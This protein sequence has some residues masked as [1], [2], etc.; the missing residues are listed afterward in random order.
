[1]KDIFTFVDAAYAVHSNMRI[2]TG[3]AMSMGTGI[4]H[5]K[6]SKQ[7]INV[8]SSTEAELVGVSEYLPYNIWL[9]MF[10]KK[11]GYNIMN[12]V[13]YQDNKS[14]IKMERN[15]RNSCTGNSRHINVRYFFVKDRVDKGEIVVEHCPTHLMIGDYF[16][17]PLQGAVFR[18]FRNI[19]MGY[20]TLD[21][22][23]D[24]KTFSL[25]ERVEK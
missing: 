19:I 13:L 6:S 4:L 22:L 8:K 9:M 7:K 21:S 20:E 14:A 16:T 17:K 23:C 2:H 24:G 12:N 3:G 25:K 10:L 18:R 15:G 1:M 5:G 11:Q